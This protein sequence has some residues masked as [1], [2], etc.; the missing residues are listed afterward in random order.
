MELAVG[1]GSLVLLAGGLAAMIRRAMRPGQALSVA[2]IAAAV[3]LIAWVAQ[4]VG[5]GR[6]LGALYVFLV[7]VSMTV[8]GVAMAIAIVNGSR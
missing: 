6:P 7:V 5:H 8:A 3:A 2:G 1:A 4:I